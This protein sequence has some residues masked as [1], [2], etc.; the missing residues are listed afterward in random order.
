LRYST[1]SKV[2]G[3]LIRIFGLANRVMNLYR[4]ESLQG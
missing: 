2:L 1:F 3:S 4:P